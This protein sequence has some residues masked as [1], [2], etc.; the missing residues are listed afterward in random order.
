MHFFQ[1]EN[2]LEREVQNTSD[3][4]KYDSGHMIHVYIY[5]C[6]FVFIKTRQITYYNITTSSVY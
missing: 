6:Y 3:Q 2:S 1:K 5:G 4:K